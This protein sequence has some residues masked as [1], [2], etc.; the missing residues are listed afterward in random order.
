MTLDRYRPARGVEEISVITPLCKFCGNPIAA[1]QRMHAWCA[2]VVACGKRFMAR[3]NCNY[4]KKLERL[5]QK[6]A[7]KEP[8]ETPNP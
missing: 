2:R 8:H 7:N 4:Q 3:L 1:G 6:L 5:S